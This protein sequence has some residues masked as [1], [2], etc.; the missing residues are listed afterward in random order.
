MKTINSNT[1]NRHFETYIDP[2]TNKYCGFSGIV[3]VNDSNVYVNTKTGAGYEAVIK[4]LHKLVD[5][6]GHKYRLKGNTFEDNKQNIIVHILEGIPKYNPFKNTKI[7]TFIQMRVER[8][9]INEIRNESRLSKNANYLNVQAYTIICSCGSEYSVT[10][11]KRRMLT[12]T[13]CNKCGS[14]ASEQRVLA[15]SSPEVSLES[16]LEKCSDGDSVRDISILQNSDTDILNTQ[17]NHP[18]DKIIHMHD[19]Q[20]WLEKEDPR[21]A[22]IVELVCFQDLSIKAAAEQVGLTGAGANM[23]LKSL[24]NKKIVREL[25]G[26]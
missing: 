21:I 20:K 1:I 3:T 15:F 12:H 25:L 10:V 2:D 6:L 24:R 13:K 4:G 17:D 7:S 14:L 5:Y 9:L 19:I 26:R 11:A 23:K 16:V 22:K 8:R 18:D